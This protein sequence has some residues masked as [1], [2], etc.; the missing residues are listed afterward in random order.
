MHEH[1]AI[2]GQGWIRTSVRKTGQIY[3]L[4]PLTTRPPVHIV[5]RGIMCLHEGR[6]RRRRCAMA[7]RLLPVNASSGKGHQKLL[8]FM[9]RYI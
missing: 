7:K 4:L 9:H 1:E 5:V 2:G 3:S 8:F 6:S